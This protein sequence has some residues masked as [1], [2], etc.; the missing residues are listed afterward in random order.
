VLDTFSIGLRQ[1]GR[2]ADC[3]FQRIMCGAIPSLPRVLHGMQF[4]YSTVTN[5][6][7]F[8][9]ITSAKRI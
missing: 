9:V 4:N 1:L 6:F 8:A 3:P 7:Y 5:L 2:A